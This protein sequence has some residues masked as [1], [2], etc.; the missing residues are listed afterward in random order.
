MQ[1]C[2]GIGTVCNGIGA[3]SS[4][5]M[6]LC[7]GIGGVCLHR[8]A[9]KNLCISAEVFIRDVVPRF[10]ISYSLRNELTGFTI[11]DLID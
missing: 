8:Q 5:L 4:G 7:N 10:M 6:H 2:N 1:S 9:Q 3:Q 11:A